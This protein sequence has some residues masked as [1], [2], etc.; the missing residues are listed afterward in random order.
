MKSAGRFVREEREFKFGDNV[1]K[2]PIINR[3]T[4]TTSVVVKNGET[5]TI[6]GLIMQTRKIIDK[7]LG[8]PIIGGILAYIPVLNFFFRGVESLEK[9]SELVIF[10]T[11]RIIE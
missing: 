5:V 9:D 6:G 11:L 3:R 7:R 10:I 1:Q 8:V 2:L 4:E